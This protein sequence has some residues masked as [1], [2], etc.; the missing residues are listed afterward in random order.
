MN[1]LGS[2]QSWQN[3]VT[4]Q[5][6]L[7]TQ[8]GSEPKQP[9]LTPHLVSKGPDKTEVDPPAEVGL[10]VLRGIVRLW[11]VR[12]LDGVTQE[13]LVDGNVDEEDADSENGD[14]NKDGDNDDNDDD[15]PESSDVGDA[16]FENDGG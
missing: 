3:S 7:A 9:L 11:A 8:P 13:K 12:Q 5:L 14:V 15:A 4:L 10:P 2:E 1:V 6:D 16:D